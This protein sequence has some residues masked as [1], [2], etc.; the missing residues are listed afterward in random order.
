MEP[1]D[2]RFHKLI[3]KLK[4]NKTWLLIPAGVLLLAL[5]GAGIWFFFLR[6]GAPVLAK[7]ESAGASQN[8]VAPVSGEIREPETVQ[9]SEADYVEINTLDDFGKEKWNEGLIRYRGKFYRYKENLQNYLFLG[10]DNDGI[11]EPAADGISGGQSDAMFLLVVD[12]A[13]QEVS[14]IAINRNTIVPIDVY[15][16]EGNF[17]VQMDLQICLQHGYGDGMKLSCMRSVEAV[18]RLFRGIPI[19]GYISLNMGGL[20][21]V[22]DAI[23]GVELTPIESIKRGEIVLQKGEPL[24]LSGEQAYVYLRTRDVDEFGSANGRLERQEQYIKAF[25]A[26]LMQNPSLGNKL[27][28]AG[29]DYMVASIDLPKLINSTKDMTFDDDHMYNIVGDTEFAD[30]F[31]R[32]NVNEQAL[33]ELILTVF[34][35]EMIS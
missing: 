22:N 30:G 25:I 16:R 34:Y 28:E 2:N 29:K 19:S 13:K 31:E 18:D 4:T 8:A 9:Q 20:A 35:E 11:V 23:G 26:K 27:Y 1:K 12:H 17:I 21:D 33:I 15:D 3:I 24:T 6:E 5:I 32:Y 14:I 7:T 10:I